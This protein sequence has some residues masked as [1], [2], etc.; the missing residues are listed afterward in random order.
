MQQ[1]ETIWTIIKKGHKK[2]IPA[3]FGPNPANS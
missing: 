3:K 1:T 2:I